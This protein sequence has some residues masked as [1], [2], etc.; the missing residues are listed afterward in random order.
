M[1]LSLQQKQT[2]RHRE[3][4]CGCRG[5][6]SRASGRDGETGVWDEQMQ[7]IIYRSGKQGPAVKHRELY[8]IP[9]D[10]IIMENNLYYK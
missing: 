9:C 1:N 3:Q 4:T 7:T 10:E 2:P 6:D 5:A 8:S